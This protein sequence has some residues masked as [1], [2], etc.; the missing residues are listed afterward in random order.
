MQKFSETFDAKMKN[1]IIVIILNPIHLF[2]G[3]QAK[4]IFETN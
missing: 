3:F 1:E 2:I 4:V